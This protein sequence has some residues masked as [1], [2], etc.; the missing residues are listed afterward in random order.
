ML[1]I[2]V[3]SGGSVAVTKTASHKITVTDGSD[4]YVFWYIKADPKFRDFD[5]VKDL[6]L[7]KLIYAK[8]SATPPVQ[9]ESVSVKP[10]NDYHLARIAPKEY[11]VEVL[12]Q[13]P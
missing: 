2:T 4:T 10:Y 8:A 5:K 13:L 6:D 7:V 9:F 12:R 3:G 1:D 11:T